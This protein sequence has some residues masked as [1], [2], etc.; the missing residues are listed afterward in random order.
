M[1]YR[2]LIALFFLI[3]FIIACSKQVTQ[4]KSGQ[5]DS[6][7]LSYMEPSEQRKG[8][9][10]AGKKYLLYGGY[11]DSGIP[12]KLFGNF[13]GNSKDDL[14]REGIAQGIP[15]NFNA[16][17][18]DE[19]A[20]IVSPNCLQCHAGYIDGE[21]ILGLGNTDG[22]FTMNTGA[23]SPMLDAVIASTFGQDSPQ[24]KSYERFSQA[25]KATGPEI[26]T[27]VVGANSADKIAAVLAAH[28]D[29]HSLEWIEEEMIDLPDEVV[30]TDVPPWWLLK[31]KNA[32]FYTGVG[33]GD[34]ARISMASSILT[35]K[36]STKAREV[37]ENFV[38]VIA[39]LK[40]LEAPKYKFEIDQ[41]LAYKGQS[42]FENNCSKCH[43][44]YGDKE[45]YPNYL[46]DVELVDTDRALL[47][48]NFGYGPF[49]DWYNGSWFG[50]MPNAA[51]LVPGDGYVAP[52]LDGIWASAPYLH[53]GSV[54][55]VEMLLNSK[56]RPAI[57]KK[58]E[59]YDQS[60][61]GLNYI[62][63]E[64]KADKFTYDTSLYGY[65]NHGHRFG[66]KLSSEERMAVIEYLKTL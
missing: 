35:L 53:N 55:T 10:E 7:F 42:I 4:V 66:D 45:Y 58:Q 49:V 29:Q 44:T 43:G 9:A 64:E 56:A 24:W 20:E 19:G 26:I 13:F 65:G 60:A 40:S 34:Y 50:Q 57:W 28:R 41:D 59:G 5:A 17:V 52:P 33:R 36:D 32:M 3:F 25:I 63:L 54:P 39:F 22:D 16:F 18:S 8:D 14:K 47:N 30:P 51:K 38:N 46:V 12:I 1:N 21:F 23:V 31:K 37:D 48:A 6:P 15:H 62:T 2:H 61:L 11:V 27:E